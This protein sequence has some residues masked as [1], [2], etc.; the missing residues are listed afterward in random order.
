M[1]ILWALSGRQFGIC[2]HTVRPCVQLSSPDRPAYGYTG[3]YV[4]T[5]TDGG[6]LNWPCGCA[7]SCT[8]TGPNAVH[9]PG[10]VVAVT[11]VKIGATVLPQDGYAVEGNV[12]YRL[13]GP[14]PGQNLN[15]PAGN[16][17]TWTV[18]YERGQAVPSGVDKLTGLLAQEMY[19]ACTGNGKCRLPRNVT[20]VTRQGVTYQVYNPQDIYGSGKTGLPEIDSWLAAVNP[21]TV[22]QAPVVL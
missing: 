17:G 10:P 5:R 15:A 11:E 12:L 4:L 9:L 14:W 18:T 21:H 13:S 6:W 20:G 2:S 7:G 22:T 16:E 8:L 1:A 3:S 19:A